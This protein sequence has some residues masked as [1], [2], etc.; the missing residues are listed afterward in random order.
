MPI[1]EIKG[2]GRICGVGR[3]CPKP[4]G[5]FTCWVDMPDTL[6]HDIQIVGTTT[7]PTLT[8]G[9]IVD[10]TLIPNTN[11]R[12]EDTY[13]VLS[14]SQAITGRSD[15]VK[16]L[17]SLPGIGR[18]TA[19]RVYDTLGSDAVADLKSDPSLIDTVPGI[20]EKQKQHIL[21]GITS[22]NRANLTRQLIPSITSP[23]IIRRIIEF[24]PSHEKLVDV[25]TNSPYDLADD[26]PGISF[27][28]ADKIALMNYNP[29]SPYRV[30]HGMTYLLDNM[31]GND[32]YIDLDDDDSII[33]FQNDLE[34]LLKIQLQPGELI[35]R[36]NALIANFPDGEA[37]IIIEQSKQTPSH[38]MMMLNKTHTYMRTVVNTIIA[39]EHPVAVDKKEL[40]N[41]IREYEYSTGFTLT[42]EQKIAVKTA[43]SNQM[44]VI[45]GG[46][47]RGKT[48][49]ID[50]IASIAHKNLPTIGL[51]SDGV[52]LLAPTG[53][54]MAKL[55][56]ATQSKYK[57]ATIDKLIVQAQNEKKKVGRNGIAE[58]LKY[59]LFIVDEMSM[60]DLEKL[61]KLFYIFPA[62]CYCFVGDTGQL[63]PIG[64]GRM[65][66][67]IIASGKIPTSTLT[68]SL[69]QK[70]RIL[71]N[72]TKVADG[73]T[74]IQW[75]FTEMP[76]FPQERDD[77]EALDFI[78]DQYNEERINQPDITNL[79]V[80][81]PLKKGN[82]GVG[83]LNIALQNAICP[84][85]QTAPVQ[86]FRRNAETYGTR[87]QPIRNTSYFAPDG[88]RTTFRVGDLVINTK[89]NYQVQT[90]KY[91]K[92]D[93][94]NGTALSQS[95]GIFNG[96][97][98]TII[99][100]LAN[101]EDDNGKYYDYAVVQFFDGSVAELNI[102]LGDFEHIELAY[103]VT[104][105]KSQGSEYKTVI[106]VSP[107]SL[108]NMAKHG[109]A[110]RNLLYTGI[111]RAKERVVVIG[112]KSSVEACIK[113]PLQS[114]KSDIPWRL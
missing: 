38:R 102:T 83:R 73:D 11:K 9:M 50:C 35:A 51:R 17:M 59:K 80:L 27:H 68:V 22:Q 44:S 16:Y 88:T 84:E 110:N 4:D 93:Y 43:L 78:I 5:W 77:Q 1:N 36:V 46:P 104:V 15:T 24:Y 81:C 99:A 92:D 65:L 29:L 32:L 19:Q 98:G 39:H 6:G 86:D 55:R 20:T 26:I 109:F 13:E 25:V 67:D 89:N 3:D 14:I 21:A 52:Y 100:F 108:T 97:C 75:D 91:S 23:Q 40:A 56:D 101:K 33:R 113:T 10:L 96:D 18:M 48:T 45:T 42:D 60:V 76:F 112:T 34:G 111:T 7:M 74:D 12:F 70:G 69:R 8:K 58:A 64:Q 114:Y 41:A 30:N 63:P 106:Y 28:A 85:V 47:G 103:A 53:K 87:G 31:S 61:S 66:H 79:V 2:R 62:A 37:P 82:T 107:D 90:T 94:W 105:H 71:D 57:T 49:I 54:A 95:V 72:A